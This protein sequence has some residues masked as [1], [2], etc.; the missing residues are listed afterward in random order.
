[1]TENIKKELEDILASVEKVRGKIIYQLNLLQEEEMIDNRQL[2][3]LVDYKLELL[4]VK[5]ILKE[6]LENLHLLE[7]D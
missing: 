6:L 2:Q 5:I 3:L 1:M 7:L 4:N